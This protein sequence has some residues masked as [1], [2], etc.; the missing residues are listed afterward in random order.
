MHFRRELIIIMCRV[1]WFFIAFCLMVYVTYV[2]GA[3]SYIKLVS[4]EINTENVKN[5]QFHVFT[6]I[7]YVS[8]STIAKRLK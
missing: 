6:I 4:L 2:D 1:T 5:S 7:S 8:I 3:E